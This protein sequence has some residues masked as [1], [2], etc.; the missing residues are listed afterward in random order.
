MVIAEIQKSK[1]KDELDQI[2]KGSPD[3]SDLV[4]ILTQIVDD[5]SI[6]GHL[7][8]EKT[9]N[10]LDLGYLTQESIEKAI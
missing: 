3:Q 1:E 7:L 9:S 4:P 2:Y 10:M 6:L 5:D 8:E